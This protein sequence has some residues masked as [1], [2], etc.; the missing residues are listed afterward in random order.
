MIPVYFTSALANHLWQS[1]VFA[2]IAGLLTLALRENHARTR[3]WLWLTAS[4]KFLI[5][6]SLLAAVGN[7]LGWLTGGL[8]ASRVARPALSVVM[9]QISQPF[10]RLQSSAAVVSTAL[11]QHVSL[12]PAVLL[13]IWTC[14]FA[15]VAFSWWLRW[16]RVRAAVRVG[17]PLDLEVALET[18]VPMLSSPA[19]LEPGVF[20]IFRP[21]LLL[22]Q[23][24]TDR[25]EPAHLKA[26]L[27]HELCHVRRRD[28]LAAA[29]H[30]AVEAIFWF[31]PL[32]WWVGARLVEER[33]HACDE[34]VLRLG[35]QPEVYAE[36]ILQTCQFYLESPLV[37]MSGIAGSDLKKRITRIMTQR[38]ARKLSFGRKVLLTAAGMAAVAGPIVFGVINAPQGRAQSQPTASTPPPSFDVASIKP[39]HGG[40]NLFRIR[41]EPGRFVANNA[42]PRF[43]LQYAYRV[44]DAQIVGAPSWIDSEH[45]DIEAKV[46][47]SSGDAQ[48]KLNR[49]EEG[50]QLRLMLQ[51]LL[52][53]RFKLTL[54]HDTKELPLYALVVAKNGPRL[55]ES[56]AAPDDPAPLGPPTPNGPQPRNSMRMMGRGNLSINAGNLDMFTELLS[57]QLG[58]LIVNK[59]GLKGNYDFTLKWTPDEGQGQMPGGPPADTAP[60]ADASGPSIF[61]ALQEQLGLKLESQK[62]PVDTIVIDH[63]ERPSEN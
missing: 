50:T 49:D 5:P 32:V 62:G 34:E 21:V 11:A 28:N 57:H 22:P 40:T 10:P 47:D 42:T 44:K 24:I 55:H 18:D 6:F 43:L 20:G 9:E 45:Y 31:H 7:R 41:A 53:D 4:A 26:I 61:T 46:D 14:G 13:A 48:R 58:L 39:N 35:S 56:A 52:A 60:P 30:M 19:M 37:C 33:E 23:G 2:G 36:G 8:T 1:T 25:L 12:M 38:L 51:S 15:A 63:V 29:I 3:Y 59:T 16:R 27:A 54:H 17:S